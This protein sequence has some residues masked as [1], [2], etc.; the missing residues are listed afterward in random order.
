MYLVDFKTFT[1]FLTSANIPDDNLPLTEIPCIVQHMR[2]DIVKA[3]VEVVELAAYKWNKKYG[4]TAF[5]GSSNLY[6]I[7]GKE[8]A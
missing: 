4:L 1:E 6:W 8:W 3:K 7:R 5:K 2:G